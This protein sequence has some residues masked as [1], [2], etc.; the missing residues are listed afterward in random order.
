MIYVEGVNSIPGGKA[1]Y[2]DIQIE[3]VT[4]GDGILELRMMTT[5]RKQDRYG[6][7][8]QVL[9]TKVETCANMEKFSEEMKQ[10]WHMQELGK[11]YDYVYLMLVSHD[12]TDP[13]DPLTSSSRGMVYPA[14]TDQRSEEERVLTLQQR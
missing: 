14:D 5:L 1:I 2:P 8:K 13:D 10:H 7:W 11:F 3:E 6:V 12:T 4:T 9:V